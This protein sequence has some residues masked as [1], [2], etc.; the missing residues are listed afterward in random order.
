MESPSFLERKE[1]KSTAKE[2]L[3][4]FKEGM[5]DLTSWK[6]TSLDTTIFQT[7]LR[8]FLIVSLAL[9]AASIPVQIGKQ[10]VDRIKYEQSKK[11]FQD[12]Y[13]DLSV[14][15][16]SRLHQRAVEAY[17]EHYVNSIPGVSLVS[18][19]AQEKVIKRME[20]DKPEVFTLAGSFNMGDWDKEFTHYEKEYGDLLDDVTFNKEESSEYIILKQDTVLD[21]NHNESYTHWAERMKASKDTVPAEEFLSKMEVF[22]PK[23]WIKGEVQSFT[24]KE[25][26][27]KLTAYGAKSQTAGEVGNNKELFLYG[28][29][30]EE[31]QGE[32]LAHELG[33]END[34]ERSTK[35]SPEQRLELLMKVHDRVTSENR[36]RSDY[37]ESILSGEL[38]PEMKD[39]KVILQTATVE[40]WAEITGEYFSNGVGN[41]ASEDVEVIE[42]MIQKVDPEFLATHSAGGIF[43]AS[44]RDHNIRQTKLFDEAFEE[45]NSD[46]LNQK[47]YLKIAYYRR[48][49][50][51]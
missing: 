25:Q 3:K 34:W 27:P 9:W 15:S 38:Y 6:P 39:P 35:L 4:G 16:I 13:K 21:V 50:N 40:Y 17:G 22:F 7:Y 42:W 31:S 36:F 30:T 19:D 29:Q 24:F 37:V 26:Y 23:G 45:E 44:Y 28:V 20:A 14:E 2:L 43:A 1:E 12:K 10:G 11:K 47:D 48:Y 5:K 33:H 41:L 18:G 46:S 49:L 32:T 8:R 51:L